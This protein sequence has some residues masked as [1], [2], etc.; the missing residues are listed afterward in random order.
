MNHQKT[1]SR[2]TDAFYYMMNDHMTLQRE[3]RLAC[4]SFEAAG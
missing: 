2:G 1:N 4:T 3:V